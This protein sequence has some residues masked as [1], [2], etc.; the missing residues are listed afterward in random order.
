MSTATIAIYFFLIQIMILLFILLLIFIG[1]RYHAYKIRKGSE[2]LTLVQKEIA[3]FILKRKNPKQVNLET[4]AD[5]KT[6]LIAL[7]KFDR[8]M[9]GS[10]W[11]AIKTAVIHQHLLTLAR[12]QVASTNWKKRNFSARV[13]ALAPFEEDKRTIFKLLDDPVYL[14][15]SIASLA[16]FNL[17]EKSAARKILEKMLEEKGYGYFYHRDLFLAGPEVAME[18]VKEIKNDTKNKEIQHVCEDILKFQTAW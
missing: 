4:I 2:N 12:E 18:W 8:Y 7:E 14:V 6:I 5:P 16:V 11:T 15:S 10:D 13:F 17:N 1:N 9:S 3:S